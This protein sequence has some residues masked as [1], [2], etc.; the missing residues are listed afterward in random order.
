M[1]RKKQA[2]PWTTSI[3]ERFIARYG[4]DLLDCLPQLY[5]PLEGCE[6]V[7]IH[8]HDLVNDLFV[9]SYT[10]ILHEWCEQ[11][12][13]KSTGHL[14]GGDPILSYMRH[15]EYMQVPGID[16][17]ALGS[18][19]LLGLRQLDSAVCQFRK[20]GGLCETFGAAGQNLTME[21]QKWVCNWLFLNSVTVLTPH[22]SSYSLRG[23]RKRDHPPN[24]FYQQPWWGDNRLMA[25]YQARVSYALSQ[26][27]R[28][29]DV[30][31]LHVQDSAF[32]AHTP[33]RPEAGGLAAKKLEK[34]LRR[35]LEARYDFDLGDESI[36]ARHGS[37]EGAELAVGHGR[38]RCVVIPPVLTIR[39]STLTLLDAFMK[40]GGVVIYLGE[41]PAMVDGLPGGGLA[42]EALLQGALPAGLHHLEALLRSKL[43]PRIRIEET[44]GG[45][46]ASIYC[47]QRRVDSGYV[48]FIINHGRTNAAELLI[49]IPEIGRLRVMNAENGEMEE[50]V[51]E[52]EGAADHREVARGHGE[53]VFD[54][55]EN[56]SDYCEDASDYR[57]EAS[58]Y[59]EEASDY[60]EDASD[61]REDASDYR[62]VVASVVRE[63]GSPVR[64]GSGLT[65][66]TTLAPSGSLI[67]LLDTEEAPST[68]GGIRRQS[69][70]ERAVPIADW[71]LRPLEPNMLLLDHCSVRLPG[72]Q[73]D[74]VPLIHWKAEQSI[75]EA[76]AAA[77]TVTYAFRIASWDGRQAELIL[78]SP[79]RYTIAVNGTVVDAKPEGW[80]KDIS[81]KR[82]PL[83]QGCLR[84]GDNTISISGT[85]A[86]APSIEAAYLIGD[87]GVEL[88][89]RR[90]G[91]LNRREDRCA[92]ADLTLEGYPLYA[93]SVVLSAEVPLAL[94]PDARYV[95]TMDAME[96]ITAHLSV[97]GA[98]A[99]AMLWRPYEIDVTDLLREGRN[100]ISLRIASSLHNLLGPHHHWEGEIK[101]PMVHFGSFTDEANWSRT[102]ALCPFGV[103]GVR[104]VEWQENVKR[105][106]D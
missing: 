37:V 25:D 50:A 76:N 72:Q 55:L 36:L 53:D 44:N 52:L 43:P 11:N 30:L 73:E 58:D 33:L 68:G 83:P 3:P 60:R 10:K 61:Y 13:L 19:Q 28:V 15:F 8:F 102:Y 18:D 34:V 59:R 5:F 100:R 91:V 89:D 75:R 94:K 74:G 86:D 32:A 23:S 39:A 90:I 26:G 78:E 20:E 105:N 87:F 98:D 54:H 65:Y 14:M 80:W 77:Y 27:V 101:G 93:G 22:L 95:L 88:Q 41:P 69:H 106:G 40:G 42:Y 49:R 79:E 16:H 29:K 81:F 12:G 71:E 57:E 4:Y 46:A 35:L 104:L 84:Q 7:R 66:R 62:E 63:D 92:G 67:L 9:E 64:P 99:G 97:N 45:A 24:L 51:V 82:I 70:A 48:Y 1:G 6:R 31:V 56:A 38:Y 47:H 17:L 21:D 85:N 103:Q 2:L 96:A